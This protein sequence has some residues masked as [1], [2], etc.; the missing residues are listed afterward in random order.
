MKE[1]GTRGRKAVATDKPT[2]V[3]KPL[4]DPMVIKNSQDSRGL[5]DSAS[6][7]ES[8]R[9]KLLSEIDYLLDQLVTSEEGPRWWGRVFPIFTKF[10]CEKMYAQAV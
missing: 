5:S 2:I 9:G 1:M 3:P 4:L 6:T 8:N 10:R 7:N